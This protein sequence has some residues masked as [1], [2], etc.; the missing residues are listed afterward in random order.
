MMKV[1]NA[2]WS[3][4]QDLEAD[5]NP[6]DRQYR[7]RILAE[8]DS[9]FSIGGFPGSNLLFP[10]RLP[11]P[12]ILVSLAQPGDTIRRMSA[13][14]SNHRLRQAKSRLQ[15]QVQNLAD[16]GQCLCGDCRWHRC[17]R[18]VRCYQ[19]D[20]QAF[21]SKHHHHLGGSGKLRQIL[22]MSAEGNTGCVNHRFLHGCRDHGIKVTLFDAANRGLQR[23]QY[24][25]GIGAIELPGHTGGSQWHV[26]YLQFTGNCG[27][28][29]CGGVKILQ[30][31]GDT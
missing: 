11:R 13:I 1:H 2:R 21:G 22:G 25:A 29:R 3:D 7:Y 28:A 17:Q 26:K 27:R 16:A 14:A 12:A 8:G 23:L 10:L 4:V 5:C 20:T 15:V 18:Q 19:G 30:A 6:D 24:I 31:H 9:W